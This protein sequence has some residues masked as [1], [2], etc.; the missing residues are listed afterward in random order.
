MIAALTVAGSDSSGGAGIQA[1]IKAFAA[2]N[3]HGC[4]VVTCVT[5]Q[6]TETVRSV[7][8]L[9]RSVIEDQLVEVLSDI[10]IKAA[11]TGMLYSGEIALV[12]SKILGEKDFPIVVDPVLIATVGDT[13]HSAGLIDSLKKELIPIADILCPNIHEASVLAEIEIRNLDDV[14][15]ACGILH[16]L[17]AKHILIKGGHIG[18]DA[19]DILYDGNG[20][21]EFKGHRFEGDAHGS[22]CVLSA[23]I[24]A[25]LAHNVNV[26]ESVREAKKRISLG[27]QFGYSIGSGV[28][29]V[30]SQYVVDRFSVLKDL[31][32]AVDELLSILPVDSVP[33]VGINFGFALPLATDVDDVCGLDGRLVRVGGRI[34]SAGCLDFGTSR[35]IA[36]IILETMKF[37]PLIRSAIN[38]KYEELTLRRCKEAGLTIASYERSKEPEGV[39]SMEWGTRQAITDSGFV[40]DVIYD[41]GAKGKEP[42]IRL[43]GE[44]PADVL[45]KLKKI[46]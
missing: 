8:P 30:N 40:P 39:S 1:D 23:L 41:E 14:K 34:E 26:E 16:G 10:D 24:T 38:L 11:K 5:A 15:K 7:Y 17:G 21:V 12:V 22:G 36:R 44:N 2:A 35:H 18:E 9:P 19:T 46:I 6:S 3:V 28:R 37:S 32:A 33:E 43:L 4:S 13:L 31:S 25:Y 45:S 20:Y 42:M 29:V 27:F